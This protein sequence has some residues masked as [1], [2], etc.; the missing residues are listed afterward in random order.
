MDWKTLLAYITGTVDPALLLRNEYLVIEHRIL[1]Q[2]I[3]GRVQWT[4]GER[5]TLADLGYAIAHAHCASVWSRVLPQQAECSAPAG[6]RRSHTGTTGFPQLLWTTRRYAGAV[7]GRSK[8][9]GRQSEK[10]SL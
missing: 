6:H 3:T 4:D 5:K 10:N 9:D 8:L 1:R 2:Q 7:A